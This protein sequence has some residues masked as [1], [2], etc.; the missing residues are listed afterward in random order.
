MNKDEG[1]PD[2]DQKKVPLNRLTLIEHFSI[3]EKNQVFFLLDLGL[4][5]EHDLDSLMDI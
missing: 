2:G 1:N 3:K 4:F 5:F